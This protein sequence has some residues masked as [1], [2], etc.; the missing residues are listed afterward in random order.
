LLGA[1]LG[2][3]DEVPGADEL[4]ISPSGSR[5]WRDVGRLAL[6]KE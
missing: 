6:G 2:V 3:G 1:A 5:K 4:E